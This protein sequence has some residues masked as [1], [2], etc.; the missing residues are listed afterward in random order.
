V[1]RI[2][3]RRIPKFTHDLNHG[4]L[5]ALG[6]DA[7]RGEKIDAILLVQRPNDDLELRIG[8]TSKQ[9]KGQQVRVRRIFETLR[10]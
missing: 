10:W 6:G 5:A 7:R 9:V 1:G 3:L 8:E 2:K 4:A